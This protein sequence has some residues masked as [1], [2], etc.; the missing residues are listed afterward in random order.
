MR[1]I[2]TLLSILLTLY[3]NA[4][5]ICGTATEGGTVTL[6]APAGNVFTSIEYASYGTSTGSCGSFTLGSCNAINSVS[7]CAAVFV[8]QSSASIGANNGVFGDPCSGTGKNLYIQARYSSVL[9]LKLVSFTAQKTA[10]NNVRLSWSSY[11]EINTS[12][13]VIERSTDGN[14]FE[15]AGSVNATG[16]GNNNYS[17]STAILSTTPTYYYRLKMVDTDGRQQYS[18]IVRITNNDETVKLAVFPNPATE[19]IT[20]ASS[21]KQELSISNS[22]GQVVTSIGMINGNQTINIGSWVPGIY[23][24]KTEDGVLKFIKN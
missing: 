19:F 11:S 24:I 20:L 13:F 17:F 6:T 4:Q 18:N 5:V 16:N 23:F 12:H 22:S 10:Q 15:A 21:K 7:I 14:L 9:P 8:G 1:K 2:F 3:S